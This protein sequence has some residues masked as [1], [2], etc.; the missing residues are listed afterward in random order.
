M[1]R[2][3]EGIRESMGEVGVKRDVL[4]R[5]LVST[6]CL[7]LLQRLLT[8]DPN[9]RAMAAEAAGDEWFMA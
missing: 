9:K 8:T 5:D 6:P 7:S 3:V 2:S 4:F 1:G